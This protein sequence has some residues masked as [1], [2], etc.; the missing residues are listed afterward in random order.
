MTERIGFYERVLRRLVDEGLVRRDWHVLVVA[1][2]P[3]D[4]DH[5]GLVEH[6]PLAFHVDEGVGRT[7]VNG[8]RVCGKEGS[9]FEEG[10]AHQ[11][12][13]LA[14]LAERGEQ[15]VGDCTVAVKLVAQ[16]NCSKVLA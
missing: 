10:P 1:G 5:G 16:T 6:D 13:R 3:V 14:F 2:G 9:R 4:R 11:K 7:E 12:T 15:Q 8:D